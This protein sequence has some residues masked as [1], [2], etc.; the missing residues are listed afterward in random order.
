MTK[1]IVFVLEDYRFAGPHAYIFGLLSSLSSYYQVHLVLSCKVGDNIL[2]RLPLD[3]ITL[4]YS[5]F[6]LPSSNPYSFS[7]YILNF[8]P[9]LFCLY[10]ILRSISPDCVYVGGGSWSVKGIISSLLIKS[11]KVV[12]H[13]NDTYAP[14]RIRLLFKFL[15]S[16]I[17]YYTFASAASEDYYAPLISRKCFTSKIIPAYVDT[18]VFSPNILDCRLVDACCSSE[19]ITVGTLV[20]INPVKG[21]ELVVASSILAFTY[22]LPFRFV[23]G[24]P[25]FSSQSEYFTRLVQPLI[26]APGAQLSF[27][28]PV[29][30]PVS[31]YASLDAYVCTSLYES[32]PISV[33]QALSM[34]LPVISTR[35]GDV[36]SFILDG[37][38]GYLIDK[39]PESLLSVLMTLFQSSTNLAN[40]ARNARNTAVT[41]LDVAIASRSHLNFFQ[42]ILF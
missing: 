21:L 14:L 11:S 42:E 39:N 24:G 28:G 33:W 29:K 34:S 26:D 31:F 20:N 27:V 16:F 12:W 3:S 22:T 23:I 5:N 30:D 17:Q 41:K 32:S 36:P 4:H 1:S 37:Y 7:R 18:E 15:S 19:T 13:L 8:I 38:N 9:D 6:T 25:V 10:R 35:V 40:L 2:S